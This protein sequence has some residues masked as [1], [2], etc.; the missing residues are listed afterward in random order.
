MISNEEEY[1]CNLVASGET[2]HKAYVLAFKI[3]GENEINDA[4]WKAQNITKKIKIKERINEIS[5]YNAANDRLSAGAVISALCD[6]AFFN[7]QSIHGST[8]EVLAINEIDEYSARAISSIEI[9]E[10]PD[11]TKKVYKF[12][13]KTTALSML[14]KHLENKKDKKLDTIDYSLIN[15]DEFLIIQKAKDILDKA[16]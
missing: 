5:H 8:G 13:S 7:P 2:R 6:I 3:R 12:H 1:F 9:T 15:E 4:Q 16:V 11:Y 14:L 10:Y